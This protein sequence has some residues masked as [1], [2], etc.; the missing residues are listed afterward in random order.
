VTAALWLALY[1]ITDV[2]RIAVIGKPLSIAGQNVLLAF[3]LS[4]AMPFMLEVL[5]LEEWY[6]ALS[7]INLSAAILRSTACGIA[8]LGVTAGL[9]RLGFRLRF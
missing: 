3:F 8:V 5:H 7:Q 4:E 6:H 1:L 2:R 9:N